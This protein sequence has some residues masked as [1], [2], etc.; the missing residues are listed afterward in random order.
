MYK[1]VA[2]C[3]NA[4]LNTKKK[5]ASKFPPRRA[6]GGCLCV[7][8]SRNL[9]HRHHHRASFHGIRFRHFNDGFI[10]RR[11]R[12]GLIVRFQH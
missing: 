1:D 11:R 10:A 2:Y 5:S 12:D 4:F 8:K 9:F 3:R 7:R 6:C